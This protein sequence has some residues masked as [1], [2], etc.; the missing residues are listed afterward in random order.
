MTDHLSHL[1]PRIQGGGLSSGFFTRPKGYPSAPSQEAQ[2]MIS[3]V[4][5]SSAWLRLTHVSFESISFS[6][7]LRQVEDFAIHFS[8]VS[9]LSHNLS[10]PF[11]YL[12]F[13]FL[14]LSFSSSP[15]SSRIPPSSSSLRLERSTKPSLECTSK[16]RTSN[17]R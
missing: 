13:Q 7:W 10:F 17:E 3:G 5:L 16:R 4:I 8:Y 12:S 14:Y 6:F 2:D 1:H 15:A 9:I 11:L